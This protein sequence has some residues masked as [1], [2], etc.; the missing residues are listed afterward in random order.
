MSANFGD[1]N[2]IINVSAIA[3]FQIAGVTDRFIDFGNLV[4]VT[5]NLGITK[6]EAEW[7]IN[8]FL[9]LAKSV[10]T[11]VKPVFTLQCNEFPIANLYQLYGSTSKTAFLQTSASASTLSCANVA[12]GDV[13]RVPG[14]NPTITSI[15]QG[16]TPLVQGVDYDL[17]GGGVKASAV[18]F[19]YGSTFVDGTQTIVITYN[20][21]AI[22]ASA[23]PRIWKADTFN[24]LNKSGY[25]EITFTDQFSTWFN[26]RITGNCFLSPSKLPNYKPD[27]FASCT[28]DVSMVGSG[29]L[30]KVE[31]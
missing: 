30:Y 17:I 13:F 25:I 4:D 14:E 11:T 24:L 7:S 28:F 10:V 5:G 26:H 21:P 6:K 23:F 22:T 1:S 29:N 12:P 8:G 18:R 2:N 31:N 9:Q 3:I 20:L 15:K 16:T 19:R 27:D